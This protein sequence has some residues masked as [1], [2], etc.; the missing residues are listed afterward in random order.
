[1]ARTKCGAHSVKPSLRA[2]RRVRRSFSE[3]GSIPESL[4]GG[5]LDC[6]AALAMTTYEAAASSS[7]HHCHS[8]ESGESSAPRLLGSVINCLGI[9]IARSSRAMTGS[10]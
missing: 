10:V 4:R 7:Q 5:R 1:M 3:G 2:Q 8:H 9:L 6:F